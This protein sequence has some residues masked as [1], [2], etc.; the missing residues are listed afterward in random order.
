ME[1][2]RY[3]ILFLLLF[4]TFAATAQTTRKIVKDFD[5]DLKKDS[6]YIDSDRTVFNFR[7]HCTNYPKNCEGF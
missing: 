2:L 1:K 3:P 5:G 7:S 4:L 6:V